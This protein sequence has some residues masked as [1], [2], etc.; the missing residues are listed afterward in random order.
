MSSCVIYIHYD[1]DNK[2]SDDDINSITKFSKIADKLLL[3]SSCDRL[4]N[5]GIENIQYF[6]GIPNNG[7]DFGK[8]QY[9]V[10]NNASVFDYDEIYVT[11]D[12][13]IIVRDITPMLDEMRVKKLD[14]WSSTSSSEIKHHAQPFF[15]YFTNRCFKSFCLWL[16]AINPFGRN[17]GRLDVVHNIELEVYKFLVCHNF[18]CGQYLPL[19][20][21][22]GTALVYFNADM[23][24]KNYKNYPFIKKK[25]FGE[26]AKG[27]INRK[28]LEGLC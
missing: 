19:H 26:Y 15:S 17:F 7:Y 12:S 14:F 1:K 13:V 21:L 9:F 4:D 2:L 23:I 24:L 5:I 10:E 3:I 16:S 25:A 8:L 22:E 28:Y 27:K 20:E 6:I 11:G 18:E